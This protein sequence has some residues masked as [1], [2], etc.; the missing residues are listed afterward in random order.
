M[1]TNNGKGMVK[2]NLEQ[3]ID[4]LEYIT[5]MANTDLGLCTN[6]YTRRLKNY[7][8]ILHITIST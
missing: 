4:N 5:T 1:L 3:N 2:V 6:L 8:C 7:H